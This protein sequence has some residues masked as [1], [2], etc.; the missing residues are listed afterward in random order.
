MSFAQNLPFVLVVDDVPSNTLILARALSSDYRVETA[1]NGPA[2]LEIAR[3]SPNPD[4]ILLDVSMPGMDGYEVLRQLKADPLTERIP[5]I[6]VTARTEECDEQYGLQLGAVDYIS[7]PYA[8][9]ITRARVRNQLLIKIR[10]NELRL[11]N[12]RLE[13]R[14]LERTQALIIARDAAEAAN[15]AKG[16]F[17]TNMSHELR[18]PLTAILGMAHLVARGGLAEP[19]R[20]QV[21]KIEMAGKHLLE[22]VSN[23]LEMARIE[24]NK[25]KLDELE[26]NVSTVIENVLQISSVKAEAKGLAFHVDVEPGFAR[27]LCGDPLRLSQVLINLLDNA[28][29]FTEQGEVSLVIKTLA[30]DECCSELYFQVTDSGIGIPKEFVP[31]L[32]E[33]FQ[34]ADGSITRQHGGSGLGLAICRQLVEMMGGDLKFKSVPGQG[35]AFF[36]Q[37]RFGVFSADEHS[38]SQ[39][40]ATALVVEDN[41]LHRMMIKRMLNDFGFSV[42]VCSSGEEAVER[43]NALHR[44]YDIV[45]MDL[46]LPGIDG[47]ETTRR[48]RAVSGYERTPFVKVTAADCDEI[49][50][51][52]EA[53]GDPCLQKPVHRK[54]LYD[55]LG[56][57]MGQSMPTKD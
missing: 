20:R 23:I 41:N 29:K 42:T 43:V 21:Q 3:R 18:T 46:G 22:L 17:L 57:V 24:G 32:F 31:R 37:L 5:V 1:I 48:L 56:Q 9:A 13:S 39:D 49:R 12:E 28:I 4:L 52:I 6:F 10:E 8:I 7:K 11:A 16:E 35:S 30:E 40:G 53:D 25:L 19:A 34:Q 44:P 33:P 50:T 2:A 15:K 36:F 26:F 55:L 27:H 14:V 51:A 45:L 54:A 47:F 38:L